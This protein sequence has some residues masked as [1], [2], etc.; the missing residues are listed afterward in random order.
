MLPPK[1]V[2]TDRDYQEYFKL[3]LRYQ[4]LCWIRQSTEASKFLVER[5]PPN[6]HLSEEGKRRMALLMTGLG[7]LMYVQ[8][9]KSSIENSAGTL[10]SA[11][12][13]Q[14]S[15]YL[16]QFEPAKKVKSGIISAFSLLNNT[17][18]ETIDKTI[19]DY[20]LPAFGLPVHGI[21]A[22]KSAEEYITMA[23]KYEQIGLPEPTREALNTAL[24][25]TAIESLQR[26]IR[27][28]LKSRVPRKHVGQQIHE[29]MLSAARYNLLG[30]TNQ[31]RDIYRDLISIEPGFEWPYAYLATME[32]TRGELEHCRD[33]LKRGARVNLDSFKILGAQARMQLA[34]WRI[35]D[36]ENT[37]ARMDYV[38]PDSDL[39]KHFRGIIQIARQG[40]M[41]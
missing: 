14:A 38:E 15:E 4:T 30:N 22:G 28:K 8:E 17:V 34:E 7:G 40:G 6:E 2:P 29:K 23:G 1:E 19:A 10:I 21:P 31:A 36:L 11:T 25:S 39:A 3:T 16:D 5:Q 9:F 32:L 13:S 37:C 26:D 35:L 41:L 27:A 20:V 24:K 33:L 12:A 18:Q